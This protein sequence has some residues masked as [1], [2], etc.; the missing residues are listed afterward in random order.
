MWKALALVFFVFFTVY[1]YGGL[2]SI[3]LLSLGLSFSL[4]LIFPL[5]EHV[6]CVLELVQ[7]LL[8]R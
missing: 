4:L 1:S 3:Y 6:L 7:Y 8:N 5:R 2:V